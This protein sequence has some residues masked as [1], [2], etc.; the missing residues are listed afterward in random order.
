MLIRLVSQSRGILLCGCPGQLVG[1]AK[2]QG[3]R[4]QVPFLLIQTTLRAAGAGGGPQRVDAPEVKPNRPTRLRPPG[5]EFDG[6]QLSPG[7]LTHVRWRLRCRSASSRLTES[8][9]CLPRHTYSAFPRRQ[10]SRSKQQRLGNARTYSSVCGSLVSMT[11]FRLFSRQV[12]CGLQPPALVSGHVTPPISPE[13]LRR[14]P[15]NQ[16]KAVSVPNAPVSDRLS[17][18]ISRDL[19]TR[20]QRTV[21]LR[22]DPC[23]S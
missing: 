9:D 1:G 21:N 23:C 5:D 13:N 4:C 15:A 6:A 12:R 19:S 14:L 17:S 2:S 8:S 22:W 18:S 10:Q 3:D 16:V 20:A 11:L 7:A